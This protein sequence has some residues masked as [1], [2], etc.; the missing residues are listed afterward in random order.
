MESYIKEDFVV[1]KM[2]EML[3]FN[4]CHSLSTVIKE[5][6]LIGNIKF[7]FD[8]TN[9]ARLDSNGIGVLS[10]WFLEMEN[11]NCEIHVQNLTGKPLDLFKQTNLISFL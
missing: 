11:N 8:A 1:I 10:R 3:C 7:I 6:L 9:L 2:P 5:N 4:N